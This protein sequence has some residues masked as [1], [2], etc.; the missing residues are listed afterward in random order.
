MG[1]SFKPT[2]VLTVDLFTEESVLCSLED[3][4]RWND[5]GWQERL[6]F[7]IAM[8]HDIGIENGSVCV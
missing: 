7:K 6:M 1:N 4:D 8:H 5:I 2:V 3:V